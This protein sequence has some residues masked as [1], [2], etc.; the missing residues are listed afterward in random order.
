MRA[1]ATWAPMASCFGLRRFK[2][3]SRRAVCSLIADL[4]CPEILEK[5]L[6]SLN[7]MVYGVCSKTPSQRF[8]SFST[9]APLQMPQWPTAASQNKQLQPTPPTKTRLSLVPGPSLLPSSR[10]L[11]DSVLRISRSA[12]TSS[13]MIFGSRGSRRAPRLLPGCPMDRANNRRLMRKCL[14]CSV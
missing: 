13:G 14:S 7:G 4:A 1:T 5:M 9:L 10:R 6:P 11:S 3:L 8:S 12:L 2:W